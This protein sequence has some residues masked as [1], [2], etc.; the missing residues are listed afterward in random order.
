MAQRL[1][2]AARGAHLDTDAARIAGL[3]RTVLERRAA[4][5]DDPHHPDFL[6]P[7]RTVL[8]LLDDARCRDPDIL[9]AALLHDSDRPDLD[10]AADQVE[11]EAGQR[12]AAIVRDLR[13]GPTGD[14][15]RLEW[16][17]QLDDEALLVALAER[18]DHARHLHLAPSDRWRDFHERFGRADLPAAARSDPRIAARIRWW[19]ESFARR[20]LKR[21]R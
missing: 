12:A 17:V 21:T 16:L 8:I 18:L 2:R 10:L 14:A 11:R 7:G 1:E 9:L 13:A 3:F 19:H 4:G 6:H 5:F 20:F 15:D